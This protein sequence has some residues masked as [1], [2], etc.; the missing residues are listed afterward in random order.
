MDISNSWDN[1]TYQSTYSRQNSEEW[2]SHKSPKG[3]QLLL[4][5]W[6][7]LEPLLGVVDCSYNIR[8]QVLEV[9]GQCMFFGAGLAA[10]STALGPCGNGAIGVK[11]FK[12]SIAL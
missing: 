12:A 7:L 5:M 8:G 11:A 9:L 1:K 2:L 10:A 6:V 4:R 3:I